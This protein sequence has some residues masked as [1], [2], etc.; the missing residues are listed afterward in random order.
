MGLGGWGGCLFMRFRA[1]AVLVQ[2]LIHVA[3]FFTSIMTIAS[4]RTIVVLYVCLSSG[5]C[6]SF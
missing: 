1:S 6:R 5:V 4:T 2:V 3:S